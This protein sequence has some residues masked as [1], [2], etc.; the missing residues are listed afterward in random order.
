MP[1][2]TQDQQQALQELKDQEGLK[3]LTLELENTLERI[4]NDVHTF[5]LVTKD[6]VQSLLYKKLEAQG[7]ERLY[8]AYLMLMYPPKA[9]K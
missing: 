7:A 5:H 6:D 2:L 8:K 9:K 1:K 4:K 3:A